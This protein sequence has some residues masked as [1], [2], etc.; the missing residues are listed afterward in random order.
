M[1]AY[2]DLIADE[3]RVTGGRGGEATAPKLIDDTVGGIRQAMCRT[4][5]SSCSLALACCVSRKSCPTKVEAQ[6]RL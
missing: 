3:L 6:P 4:R 1:P 2:T 5:A